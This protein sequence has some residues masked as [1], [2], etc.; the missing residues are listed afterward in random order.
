M[1]SKVPIKYKENIIIYVVNYWKKVHTFKKTNQEYYMINAIFVEESIK[2]LNGN[3]FLNIFFVN[4]IILI[5]EL[6][7]FLFRLKNQTIYY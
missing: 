7:F 1:A 4:K 2:P 5:C 3:Y 6:Y